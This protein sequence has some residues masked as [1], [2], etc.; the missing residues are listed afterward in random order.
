MIA[1]EYAPILHQ[2]AFEHHLQRDH[3]HARHLLRNGHR[4]APTRS[5]HREAAYLGG[6]F[7]SSGHR[8]APSLGQQRP[9]HRPQHRPQPR[10]SYTHPLGIGAG[11]PLQER[12]PE[13][14]VAALLCGAANEPATH[15]LS[16]FDC[17]WY[18][19]QQEVT[20][21]TSYTWLHARQSVG[22]PAGDVRGLAKPLPHEA[23]R[24]A[25]PP[26]WR[27]APP[28]RSAPRI[29]TAQRVPPAPPKR[30]WART[31]EPVVVEDL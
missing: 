31:A 10:T 13:P 4:Q 7:P 15:R 16:P 1:S 6:S 11:P 20:R 19:N 26:S 2:L 25:E 22:L 21:Q 17:T 18:Q 27:A 9:Q 8:R 23:E 5:A 14:R 12:K 30:P 3:A 29:P 24:R 28:A